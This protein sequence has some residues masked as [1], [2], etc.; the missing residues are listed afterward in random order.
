MNESMIEY[1]KERPSAFKTGGES[2]FMLI[3]YITS[4]ILKTTEYIKRT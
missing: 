3:L 4:P 2:D 1:E